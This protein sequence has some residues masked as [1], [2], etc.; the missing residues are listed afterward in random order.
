MT[1]R[2]Q[3]IAGAAAVP[4]AVVL[5]GVPVASAVVEKVR[6]ILDDLDLRLAYDFGKYNSD[7]FVSWRKVKKS[8]LDA[9]NEAGLSTEDVVAQFPPEPEWVTPVPCLINGEDLYWCEPYKT[10]LLVEYEGDINEAVNAL[11]ARKGIAS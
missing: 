8:M 1:N 11:I 4:I 2:R 5:A 6:P 3:F 10:P 9:G 7:E